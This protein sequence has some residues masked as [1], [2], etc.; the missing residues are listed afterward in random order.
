MKLED[1]GIPLSERFAFYDQ[2]WIGNGCWKDDPKLKTHSI[3]QGC[4]NQFNMIN[5]INLNIRIIRSLTPKRDF[6]A[7]LGCVGNQKINRI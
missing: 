4:S 2:V 7:E 5:M 6:F 3:S 1:C